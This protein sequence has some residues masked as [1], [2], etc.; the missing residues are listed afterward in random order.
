MQA[1]CEVPVDFTYLLRW[2]V[3]LAVCFLIVLSSEC[4][5]SV[6]RCGRHQLRLKPRWWRSRW[7]RHGS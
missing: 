6:W 1:R 7:R 2:F 5:G 3:S 4:W